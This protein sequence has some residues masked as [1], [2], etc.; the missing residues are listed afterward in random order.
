VAELEPRLS[1]LVIKVD[2]P[3]V[4]EKVSRDATLIDPAVFDQPV[5]LDP[6]SYEVHAEAPGFVAWSQK[7]TVRPD[8]HRETVRV[9]ALVRAGVATT[10]AAAPAGAAVDAPRDGQVSRFTTRRK[11]ALAT[12]G[13]GAIALGAGTLLALQ[14]KSLHDDARKLCP[15]GEPCRDLAASHKSEQAVSRANLATVVGVVGIAALGAGAVLWVLGAP[16]ESPG[17][18]RVVPAA[19]PDSV[20][21]TVI[22]SF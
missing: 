6:G 8:G 11:I 9:P 2:A 20:G 14:A 10:L 7:V 22:G 4:D 21:L 15:A 3:A 16:P 12:G 17:V 5:A 18:A 1:Y 13:A 19:T